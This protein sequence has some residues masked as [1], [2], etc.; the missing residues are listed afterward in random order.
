MIGQTLQERYRLDETI[1]QGGM[2]VVYRAYDTVLQRPV[3][4]KLLSQSQLGSEGPERMLVEA[5]ATARLNHPNIVAIYDVGRTNGTPFIVMELVEGQLLRNIAPDS[6]VEALKI[7]QSICDALTHAHENGIVHR[8]LKPENIFLSKSNIIKLVDFGLARMRGGPNLTGEDK[9]L[10]TFNYMA[11]ELLGGGTATPQSDLYALGIILYELVAG[12]PPFHGENLVAILSQHLNAPVTPPSNYNRDIPLPLDSLIL[13]LLR[14]E[15]QKRPRSAADV[16]EALAALMTASVKQPV[17]PPAESEFSLLDRIVRGR[18]VGRQTELQ[19]LNSLWNRVRQEQA[20]MAL[21]SGE[22]GAGKT[23]LAEEF[24]VE[25]RLR[26]SVVLRGGCYEYEAITPY[27]PLVEALR[28]W[29]HSQETADLIQILGDTA[30]ELARLAP[31]IESKLGALPPNPPLSPEEARSRLFDN[32]ARFLQTLAA[33]SSLVLFIDDLHWADT[34]TLNL[35]HYLMRRLRHERLFILANYRE[36]ELDRTHPLSASLVTWNRER[37][38]T[39]ITLGR[40]SVEETADMLAAL[41]GQDVVGKEFT[42]A[43]YKE[44]EG[45]PFFI[46]EVVKALIDQEQIYRRDGQWLSRDIHE[47]AIPQS[48]KEAIGRRLNRLSESCIEVLHTAAVLGKQFNFADLAAAYNEPEEQL[49][50][51]L[52]EAST[53]QLIHLLSGENFTEVFAFTHDKIRETLYEEINPIRRRRIHQKIALAFE[54]RYSADPAGYVQELAFHFVQAANI[55]KGLHYSL[56]AAQR[57]YD[58]SSLEESITYYEQARQCAI[59]LDNNQKQLE[60]NSQLGRLFTVRGDFTEAR[61]AYDRAMKLAASPQDKA[62]LRVKTIGVDIDAGEMDDT[63]SVLE[64]L[65]QLDPETQTLEL[66]EALSLLGRH[67]HYKAD[68]DQAVQ[69]LERAY[70]LAQAMDDPYIMT[71]ILSY[72]AGAYQHQ[73]LLR[74]C[75]DWAR[76]SVAYGE[77]NQYPPAVGLGYE[78]ISESSNLLGNWAEGYEFAIKNEEIGERLGSLS[79]TSWANMAKGWA[80]MRMGRFRE[81]ITYCNRAVEQGQASEQSR[82]VALVRYN[83]VHLYVELGQFDLAEMENQELQSL[84]AALKQQWIDIQAL[85]AQALLQ[86]IRGERESALLRL[87]AATQSNNSR[88]IIQS[89]YLFT[90]VLHGETLLLCGRLDEAEAF[91]RDLIEITVTAEASWQESVSRRILGQVLAAKGQPEA[92]LVSFN[93]AIKIQREKGS[94]P[95]LARSLLHRGR[96]YEA[97]DNSDAAASDLH[98]AQTLIE[99]MALEPSPLTALENE[100]FSLSRP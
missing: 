82:L 7:G 77:A 37:L 93:E 32:I 39:R 73:F 8:D 11:P 19:Q 59:G 14:K 90:G 55:E 81:A 99:D 4:V 76:K 26:G 66:A 54:K 50:D 80:C 13:Q 86:I 94:R 38:A 5:Q 25:A 53:A 2:G 10:G 40:F 70:N 60:I 61:E 92:A 84:A 35:L 78:F 46:E 17:I 67:Y 95:E 34:G 85:H 64:A 47:L 83:L 89:A 74:H 45:N 49:F 97:L 43:I 24:L 58:L 16:H 21:L 100:S 6:L 28:E 63:N 56:A 15:P 88:H 69:C 20:H 3:A 87:K 42:A 91:V 23:R 51:A 33:S 65:E 31:E 27:L 36:V 68:Y 48:V 71:N 41:F 96:L 9:I 52:D 22:P 1:G 18:L 29:V 57:A 30:P 75:I 72:M 79:R 44:T 98:E 12:R 62:A